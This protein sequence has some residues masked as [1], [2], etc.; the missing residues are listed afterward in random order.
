MFFVK[1]PFEMRNSFGGPYEY[2]LM[3]IFALYFSLVAY[4]IKFFFPSFSVVSSLNDVTHD[5]G[6]ASS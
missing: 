1:I 5:V 3:I 2:K 6:Y 4:T